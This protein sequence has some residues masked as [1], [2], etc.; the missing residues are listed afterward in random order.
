MF[1]L[2]YYL[3]TAR[4]MKARAI[5]TAINDF[6]VFDSFDNTAKKLIS[7]LFLVVIWQQILDKS[8]DGDPGKNLTFNFLYYFIKN[9]GKKQELYYFIKNVGKKQEAMRINN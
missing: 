5:Q 4:E 6:I 1:F 8:N 9:V 3:L 7:K 2:N